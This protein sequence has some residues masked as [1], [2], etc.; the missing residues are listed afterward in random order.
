MLFRSDTVEQLLNA[1]LLES[2]ISG[3]DSLAMEDILKLILTKDSQALQ[4]L[5]SKDILRVIVKQM[6]TPQVSNSIQ[7]F[8]QSESFNQ[9]IT[10]ELTNQWG[11]S[12]DSLQR[13][14]LQQTSTQIMDQLNLLGQV[15]LQNPELSNQV[16]YALQASGQSMTSSEQMNQQLRQAGGRKKSFD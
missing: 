1:I 13:D 9:L 8:L 12:P 5:D 7:S 16:Q 15:A 14:K 2:G 4:E 10:R 11:I 3:K 6:D